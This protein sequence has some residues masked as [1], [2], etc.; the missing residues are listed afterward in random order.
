[1]ARHLDDFSPAAFR[2]AFAAAG[3]ASA[4]GSVGTVTNTVSVT[5]VAH[6]RTSPAGLWRV[7]FAADSDLVGLVFVQHAQPGRATSHTG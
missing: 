2:D 1:M 7:Q 4:L 5:S 3:Q 6:S